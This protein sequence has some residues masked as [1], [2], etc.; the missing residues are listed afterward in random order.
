MFFIILHLLFMLFSLLHAIS[1]H[2]ILIVVS[3]DAFR[4]DYFS[5]K[6]TPNLSK[7]KERGSYAD[8]IN[9]VF[10]T[11]TFPNHH[12][13]ATGLY[14]E[15]HGVL[16]NGFYDSVKKVSFKLSYELFHYDET[17]IPIW[18]LNEMSGRD[19]FSGSMMWPGSAYEYQGKLPTYLQKFDTDLN[20]YK[21]VDTVLNW[22]ENPKRPA[23]LVMLYFEEPD[24]HGHAFGPKSKEV[25]EMLQ[26]L[27]NVSYYLHEQLKRKGLSNRVN[28]IHLSDHG[29]TTVTPSNFID[30]TK[31]LRPNTYQIACTSPALHVIPNFGMEEEI[32]GLLKNASEDIGHFAV[33]QKSEIPSRW[34]FKNNPR[35]PPI[36]VVADEGYAFQDMY[37]SV[38]YYSARYG[39]KVRNDSEF[40]VHGYDNQLPSMRPFFMA[41]GPQ[42]KANHKVA[43]FNTVDLFTLFCAILNIKSTRHDG[44]Y[45]NIETILVGYHGSMV[46]IIVIIV[47]GV[48]LALLLIIC[49]AVATLLIIK[50]QQNIT[51]TAA[52]NKRFPQNF[53]HSTIEAQHLLEPEDA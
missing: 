38:K 34:R 33:Y 20:W 15:N 1:D 13:I 21:R 4:Y 47:G 16:G 7:L 46:P 31:Y 45:S 42:I 9:N 5:K 19:R 37:E 40:G 36:Y 24:T 44:V 22:I 27:D 18:R 26:R 3:F 35:V 39:F 32:Y 48:A 11:K 14:A 50:R 10:P 12:T 2:P 30:F 41:I 53:T 51:T 25:V 8:Y 52:L 49:A 23:N 43:P 28:V 17:I 29:M 6:V